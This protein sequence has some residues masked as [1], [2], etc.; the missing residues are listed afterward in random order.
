MTKILSALCTLLLFVIFMPAQLKLT[1]YLSLAAVSQYR[2]FQR[3]EEA[4]RH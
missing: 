1:L 4:W 3:A 2:I